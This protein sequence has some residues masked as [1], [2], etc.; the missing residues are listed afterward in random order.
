MILNIEHVGGRDLSAS[1]YCTCPSE[2][3]KGIEIEHIMKT[4][5]RL[6]EYND[7]YFFNEVNKEPRS[8]TCKCG[9]QYTQ[10]WFADD[11]GYVEVVELK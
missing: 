7:S 1:F 10:Q 11:H 4:L 6:T 2:L 9:K 8:L 3:F 5:I